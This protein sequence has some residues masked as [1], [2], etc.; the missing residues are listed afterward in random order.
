M[1]LLM[2][3]YFWNDRFL[4]IFF[5]IDFSIDLNRSKESIYLQKTFFYNWNVAATLVN[6]TAVAWKLRIPARYDVECSP[7]WSSSNIRSLPNS[8]NGTTLQCLH[9][10]TR[11]ILTGYWPPNVD[12]CNDVLRTHTGYHNNRTHTAP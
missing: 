6:A 2:F 7:V 1:L 5:N 8:F 3:T 11:V 9:F 4:L 10:T 12:V